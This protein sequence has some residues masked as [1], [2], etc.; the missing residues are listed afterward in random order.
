MVFQVPS[1]GKTLV[2]NKTSINIWF[3]G[4]MINNGVER[5][6][7]LPSSFNNQKQNVISTEMQDECE[8][9]FQVNWSNHRTFQ[10]NTTQYIC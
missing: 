10:G 6:I 4:E 7:L 8:W 5:F 1:E 2:L 3:C 9:N